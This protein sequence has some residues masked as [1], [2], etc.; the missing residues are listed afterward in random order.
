MARVRKF[1]H[2][3]TIFLILASFLTVNVP[4]KIANAG[5][6]SSSSWWNWYGDPVNKVTWDKPEEVIADRGNQGPCTLRLVESAPLSGI[7]DPDEIFTK[8]YHTFIYSGNTDQTWAVVIPLT[9]S[10]TGT[11]VSIYKI[12]E[13]RMGGGSG[14]ILKNWYEFRTGIPL[15]ASDLV[16]GSVASGIIKN[17]TIYGQL[18][19]AG[20][21]NYPFKDAFASAKVALSGD[22]GLSLERGV[23]DQTGNGD[24][25]YQG[26]VVGGSGDVKNGLPPGRYTLSISSNDDHQDCSGEKQIGVCTIWWTG[27][28]V[29]DLKADRDGMGIFTLVSTDDKDQQSE[30]GKER[31]LPDG[32][33]LPHIN[34]GVKERIASPIDGAF[35][36][37]I[38]QLLVADSVIIAYFSGWINAV[39]SGGNDIDRPALKDAWTQV[40]NLTM[41]LLT[42]GLLII[43]F[44]NVLSIDIDKYGLARMIPRLIIAIVMTYFSYF[45][46]RFLLEITSA[47]QVRLLGGQGFG[48]THFIEADKVTNAMGLDVVGHFGEMLLLLIL[49]LLIIVAL[50]VLFVVLMVRVI[51]IWFLVAVAPLAFM[52]NVMPFTESLYQQWWQRWWKWSFMGP[53]VA[54]MLWLGNQFLMSYGKATFSVTTFQPDKTE[55]FVMLF[56][57]AAAIFIAAVIPFQMGGEVINGI[58]GAWGAAKT[59]RKGASW[60]LNKASKGRLKPYFEGRKKSIEARH[61]IEG[62]KTR[63]K[64]A[65]GGGFKRWLAGTDVDQAKA[66]KHRLEKQMGENMTDNPE[67]LADV[68]LASPG[69]LQSDSALLKTAEKKGIGTDL[70]KE[71]DREML[72]L[73]AKRLPNMPEL[74]GEIEDK[75]RHVLSGMALATKDPKDIEKALNKIGKADRKDLKP[76]DYDLIGRV[77]EALGNFARDLDGV[78]RALKMGVPESK[79]AASKMLIENKQYI[80]QQGINVPQEIWDKAERLTGGGSTGPSNPAP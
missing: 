15:I 35:E 8:R 38:K 18:T 52:M 69:S 9:F 43:A 71:K 10:K 28:T 58:K 46:L 68:A 24:I 59:A 11:T 37:I 23:N 36:W 63:A 48:M 21:W 65:Q 70:T 56:M 1:I 57:A 20:K 79:V 76:V 3:L 19:Q 78:D 51:V 44:A 54:F 26:Y 60:S 61:A 31:R 2:V 22:S 53:A 42:L 5:D 41:A 75:Q 30:I 39:L 40:R 34:I 66:I 49:L 32:L 62:E 27:K 67:Q 72:K 13:M 16:V 4:P 73:I 17:G 12:E 33:G 29:F 45:I 47:F 50:L 77:P 6:C 64:L 55:S 25:F 80:Q 7:G 74:A 14:D